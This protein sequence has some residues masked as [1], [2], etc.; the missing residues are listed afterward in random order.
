M[1][2]SFIIVDDDEAELHH[3]TSLHFV[4]IAFTLLEQNH[5]LHRSCDPWSLIPFARERVTTI[6]TH[7]K[8]TQSFV[9]MWV[10]VARSATNSTHH[11]VNRVNSMKLVAI[12][13][14]SVI[15]RLRSA[16]HDWKRCCTWCCNECA[17]PALS[18]SV[19]ELKT[20]DRIWSKARTLTLWFYLLSRDFV[21]SRVPVTFFATKNFTGLYQFLKSW[22]SRPHT[23]QKDFAA[24]CCFRSVCTHEH[25]WL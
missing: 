22:N 25:Q 1:L 5:R 7:S 14:T 9:R 20:F 15:N 13:H 19:M 21:T 18:Q 3:S 6:N 10:I 24:R 11:W 12:T 4:S 8:Q 2:T 16:T 17:F 23:P